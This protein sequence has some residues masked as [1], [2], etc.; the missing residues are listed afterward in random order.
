MVLLLHV[1]VLVIVKQV[2]RTIIWYAVSLFIL[3]W[4]S[5][6]SILLVQRQ[7][8]VVTYDLGHF[9]FLCTPSLEYNTT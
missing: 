6:Q 5:I 4:M 9:I 7:V 3:L 2:M 1:K 8:Y